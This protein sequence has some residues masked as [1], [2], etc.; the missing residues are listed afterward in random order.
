MS[1]LVLFP[2]SGRNLEHRDGGGSRYNGYEY[3]GNGG[4]VIMCRQKRFGVIWH[5][6]Q[7]A[8]FCVLDPRFEIP[9]SPVADYQN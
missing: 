2:E 3:A 7:R 9:N 8:C 1:R 4:V 6:V 5:H